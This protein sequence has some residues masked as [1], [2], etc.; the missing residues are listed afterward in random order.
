MIHPIER[1]K[2]R[3]FGRARDTL[4]ASVAPAEAMIAAAEAV[5]AELRHRI[6]TLESER[7]AWASHHNTCEHEPIHM[8]APRIPLLHGSAE[9]DRCRK[10]GS[11]RTTHHYPGPWQPASAL[12]SAFVERDD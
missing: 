9:W 3:E 5:I 2:L 1:G 8:T 6:T 10:C 12:A 7:P 4:R 11:Y